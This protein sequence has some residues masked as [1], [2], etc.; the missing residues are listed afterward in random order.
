MTLKEQYTNFAYTI[1]KHAVVATIV[2][3]LSIMTVGVSA[4]ELVAP[5]EYKPSTFIRNNW[6]G[7]NTYPYESTSYN[8]SINDGEEN[9]QQLDFEYNP[10]DLNQNYLTESITSCPGLSVSYL[11]QIS[12]NTYRENEST[13]S[14]I[15]GETEDPGLFYIDS[16]VEG[17]LEPDERIIF[18]CKNDAQSSLEDTDYNK[19]TDITLEFVCTSYGIDPI[20]CSKFDSVD[21]YSY[22]PDRYNPTPFIYFL[23]GLEGK[24]LIIK[25]TS[26]VP[27]ENDLIVAIDSDTVDT[28]STSSPTNTAS[29]SEESLING[30]IYISANDGNNCAATTPVEITYPRTQAVASATLKQLFN[31]PNSYFNGF[32]Q[33]VDGIYTEADL[34]V[35]KLD[36]QVR[37]DQRWDT[38]GTSCGSGYLREMVETMTQ[39]NNINGAVFEINGEYQTFQYG[40]EQADIFWTSRG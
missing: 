2:M 1:S 20:S 17:S 19:S 16:V 11:S 21:A 8:I 26:L 18:G 5:E 13:V 25:S 36:P 37:Q 22:R 12:S 31:H 28:A 10:M 7:T 3:V 27:L 33:Y 29:Q 32:N 24:T 4:A 34:L 30:V 9:S 35:I 40:D 38:L 14:R 39:W 15:F 6:P 23:R